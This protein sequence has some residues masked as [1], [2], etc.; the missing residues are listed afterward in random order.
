ML[1]P[2]DFLAGR[3]GLGL[4]RALACYSSTVQSCYLKFYRVVS[5]QLA[6]YN[7]LL[8]SRWCS[9]RMPLS[10]SF[11]LKYVP[12]YLKARCP[13]VIDCTQAAMVASTHVCAHTQENVWFSLVEYTWEPNYPNQHS[14]HLMHTKRIDVYT[15]QA[16]TG[17][18]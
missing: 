5:I 2:Q 9:I 14:P 16:R 10:H 18:A 4:L 17:G 3:A 15:C 1:C 11:D 13:A 12:T 7:T 8:L 6:S